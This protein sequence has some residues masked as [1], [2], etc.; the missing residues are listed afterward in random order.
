MAGRLADRLG[1]ARRNSFV[2]RQT[3]RDLF[4]AALQS[5]EPPFYVLHIYGL[6]GVG[7]TSLLRELVSLCAAQQIRSLWLDARDIDPSPQGFL[8]ALGT[9]LGLAPDASVFDSLSAGAERF[10]LFVDTYEL[11]APL[12]HWLRETLLPSLPDNVVVVLA[13]RNAPQEGW[14][15]DSGWRDLL[16]AVP[17]RNLNPEESRSYLLDRQVPA[18][19][20]QQVLDF[21]HGH[22]LALSLVADVFA[23]RDGSTSQSSFLNAPDAPD[24]VR[25]LVGHLVQGVP[26]ERHRHALEACAL[27]RVTTESLLSH[28]LGQPQGEEPSTHQVFE[29]LC[30]LSFIEAAQPGISPHDLAREAIMADLRWRD[31]ESYAEL[32]SEAR[33]FYAAQLQA[34]GGLEQQHILMDYVYLH[35]GNAMVRPFLEWQENG[36]LLPEVAREDELPTL[37]AMVEQHEGNEAARIA[38]H[39]FARQSERVL[40]LHERD[41]SIGGFLLQLALHQA[42]EEDI[43]VD[44]MTQAAWNYLQSHAP[45]RRGEGATMFRFWMARDTY[46]DVSPAQSLIFVNIVRHYLATPAL[47]FTFLPCA[48]PDFWLPIFSYAGATLVPEQSFEQQGRSY[49]VYT[50]DW[51]RV[52]PMA[53]L[54]LMAERETAT[55]ATSEA[56][57][58]PQRTSMIVLSETEFARAVQ[59]ALK[60]LKRPALLRENPLL[61]SRFVVENVGEAAAIDE[62]IAM[63]QASIESECE[64]LRNSARTAKFHEAL[65]H[66][67]LQPFATQ[68][69]AAE[70]MD[71]PFSTYRRY[72]KSGVERII[73]GLWQREV[74]Q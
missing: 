17:L 28:L 30:S 12:D 73:E 7:K 13:G 67:Y 23:Q 40:V 50:H 59:S 52:P 35:R 53:W 44:F 54:D 26:S 18:E 69:A 57:P 71:V 60:Q 9:T 66:T 33:T 22:P 31:P 37:I 24:V 39:W 15:L 46:Q 74:R 70:R 63:L 48:N 27:V 43:A 68:E 29:W 45:L 21:T 64:T 36:N 61:H 49:G 3:E 47:A 16:R 56:A 14:R 65:L 4:A 19:Q 34:A 51:R 42:T 20:H 5:A 32:H 25:T 72:L 62:R 55:T 58:M 10:V 2:G 1:K 11:L 8:H 41:G 38:A 6:G